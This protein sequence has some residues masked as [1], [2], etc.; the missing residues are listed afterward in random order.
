[1]DPKVFW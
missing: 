1:M